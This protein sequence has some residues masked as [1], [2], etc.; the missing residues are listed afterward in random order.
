MDME[1]DEDKHP[2]H[3][4]FDM[5]ATQDTSHH[6]ANLLVAETEYDDRPKHFRSENCIKISLEWLDTLMENDT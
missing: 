2:L 6:I 1:E 3:I 4:F 5:K